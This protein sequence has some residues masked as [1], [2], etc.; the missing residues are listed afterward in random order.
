[1]DN[2]HIYSPASYRSSRSSSLEI[3]HDE[4]SIGNILSLLDLSTDAVVDEA[5]AIRA[6]S[7]S[8]KSLPF[9][10]LS[11][12]M[13]EHSKKSTDLIERI[14]NMLRDGRE[15]EPRGGKKIISL[16]IIPSENT[17]GAQA[18]RRC[19]GSLKT[20]EV[21]GGGKRLSGGPR[22]LPEL[23]NVVELA[24]RSVRTDKRWKRQS[25][26]NSIKKIF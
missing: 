12:K 9:V 18:K 25:F 7:G 3:T 20:S 23:R 17:L 6:N 5:K 1:M 19:E 10:Y 4:N 21:Q 26:A 11:G 16:P 14:N 13:E 15:L 2:H 22:P 24:T 8:K